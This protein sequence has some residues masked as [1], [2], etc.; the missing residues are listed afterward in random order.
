MLLILNRKRK[1][2]EEAPAA[3]LAAMEW[4]EYRAEFERQYG[5]L[6]KLVETE[7]KTNEHNE[8]D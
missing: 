4:P 6:T 8:T 2:P 5:P 7:K 3:I 1:A